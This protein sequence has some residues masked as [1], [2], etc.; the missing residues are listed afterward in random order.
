M[1]IFREERGLTDGVKLINRWALMLRH[2]AL[3]HRSQRSRNLV[4]HVTHMSLHTQGEILTRLS[5]PL[6][7]MTRNT[8]ANTRAVPFRVAVSLYECVA[9]SEPL[10]TKWKKWQCAITLPMRW[11]E[12]EP[13][14]ASSCITVR[15]KE[16][17]LKHINTVEWFGP[18]FVINPLIVVFLNYYLHVSKKATTAC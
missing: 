15:G 17:R 10:I 12:S 7:N 1:S 9:I 11:T 18:K 4:N 3:N 16:K 14:C 13:A 6:S 2:P 8:K 5:P